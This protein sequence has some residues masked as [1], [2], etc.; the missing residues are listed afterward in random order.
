MPLPR[1]CVDCGV[2]ARATRCVECSRIKERKR[3]SRV[4]RGYDHY[5]RELSKKMRAAQ[6]YCSRCAST[7]DLTL[8]HIVP[9]AQG[10][11]SDQSNAMVLCRKC[12]SEKGSK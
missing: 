7:K 12:N 8:D 11:V 1:P 9:L 3:V 2:I 5:W 6:P 10:G 4:A